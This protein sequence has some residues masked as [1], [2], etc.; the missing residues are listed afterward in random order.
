MI[1]VTSSFFPKCFQFT[2]K[3]QVD[4]VKFLQFEEVFVKLR[5]RDRLVWSVGRTVEM[6][7]HFQISFD[8]IVDSITLNSLLLGITQSRIRLIMNL[9]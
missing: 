3:R 4:V 6:S 9:E 5:F 7:L 8:C 2:L 1:I